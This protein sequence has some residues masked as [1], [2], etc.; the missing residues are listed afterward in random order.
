MTF[1]R[2]KFLQLE[3]RVQHKKCAEALRKVY[4]RLLKKEEIKSCYETYHQYLDW[5]QL[6]P[7]ETPDLKHLADRYHWHLNQAVLF[8]KEHNLLPQIR[9]GDHEPKEEFSE[10]A[11]YLDNLRSAYNVGSILRYNRSSS[12]RKT[13]LFSLQL[14]SPTTKKFRKSRWVHQISSPAFEMHL[15]KTYLDRSSLLKQ[16]VTP[17]LFLNSSFPSPSPS[18]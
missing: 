1:S 7:F 17:N 16:A 11:I 5:M 12:R 2:R 15:S 6:R 3:L 9:Q 18:Y 13:P 14:P 4:E 8:L 10:V